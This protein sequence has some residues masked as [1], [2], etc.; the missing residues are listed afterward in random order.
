MTGRDRRRIA[1]QSVGDIVR[2]SS[3]H[4][5]WLDVQS[6]VPVLH[7]KLFGSYRTWDEKL[8]KRQHL[9]PM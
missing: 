1:S 5:A 6:I 2:T 7:A 3:L 8:A 9:S 4:A